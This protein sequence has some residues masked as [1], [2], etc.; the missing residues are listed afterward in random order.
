MAEK[1]PNRQRD[2]NQWAKQMVDMATM[3]DK[4]LADLKK[5]YPAKKPPKPKS[6]YKPGKRASS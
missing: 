2:T 3:D 1:H 4:E 5:K 6:G